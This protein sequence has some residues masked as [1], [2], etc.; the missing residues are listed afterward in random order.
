MLSDRDATLF[1]APLAAVLVAQNSM[2]SINTTAYRC[3]CNSADA[4]LEGESDSALLNRLWMTCVQQRCPSAALRRWRALAC[5]INCY[6]RDAAV[7]RNAELLPFLKNRAGRRIHWLVT[8]A[9][10]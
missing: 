6:G 10:S 2:E 7:A 4:L 5:G 3:C 8:V 9:Q 1:C